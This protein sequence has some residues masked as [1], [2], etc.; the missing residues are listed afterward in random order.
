MTNIFGLTKLTASDY[1]Y[2]NNMNQELLYSATQQYLAMA[3]DAAM[4]AISTFV[5]PQPTTNF[6]ER[7][8]LP[9]S[10]RMQK[11]SEE[12]GGKSV[13]QSGTWD[14]AYPLH[15]FSDDLAVTDVD[16]AYLTPQEFQSHIDGI[17]GRSMAAKRH[18]ILYRL[19]NNTQDTFTDKRHGALTVEPLA[20]GDSVVYPP[21]EGTDSTEATDDHYL[22][23]GYATSA[24]SDTNNPV[25]TLVNELVEH[26]INQTEDIPIVTFINSAQQSKIEALTNFK[27]YIPPTRIQR[28]LDTDQPLLPPANIPGKIIGY[29]RGYSWI[30]V[31]AWT[32]ANYMLSVN[33]AADQPLKMR[34][35]PAETGLG[36]GQLQLLPTERRGVITYNDWRLRFG[37][38]ASNRLASAVMFVDSGGSYTIPTAYS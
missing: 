3:N 36:G 29:L 5:N 38:G 24:I 22:V 23:S 27:P 10:G 9:I 19:Y 33:L 34:V 37:I 18:E 13:A 30:S 16:R 21:V 8:K 15:N 7:Y 12:R 35:D 28:G 25:E 6:K 1:A 26:G 20:N 14:V 4:G 2:V 31:W 17:I 11:T 32:P